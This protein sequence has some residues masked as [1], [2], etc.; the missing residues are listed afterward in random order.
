MTV[1]NMCP[2]LVDIGDDKIGECLYGLNNWKAFDYDCTLLRCLLFTPQWIGNLLIKP[3]LFSTFTRLWY[4]LLLWKHNFVSNHHILV[5]NPK[6]MEVIFLWKCT[7]DCTN[8]AC[9][10]SVIIKSDRIRLL[11]L[12]FYK[13]YIQPHALV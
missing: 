13:I 10:V 9:F 11:Q 2:V 5:C 8:W 1:P 6:K 4:D 3:F 12:A 7:C